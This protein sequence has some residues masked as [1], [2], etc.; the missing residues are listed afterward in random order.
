LSL[1]VI[2]F[3]V[4]AGLAVGTD[5][6]DGGSGEALGSLDDFFA[7][8]GFGACGAVVS[9]LVPWSGSSNRPAILDF[10]NPTDLTVLRVATGAAL[11]L[12]LLV[13]LQVTDLTEVVGPQAYPWAFAAG[14]GERIIDKR[15]DAVDAAARDMEAG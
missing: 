9:M 5:V 6:V 4:G 8:I 11:A 10:V 1:L 13:V 12:A 7:V 15:L 2:A 3:L 14:F